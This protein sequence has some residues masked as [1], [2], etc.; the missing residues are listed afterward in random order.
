MDNPPKDSFTDSSFWTTEEKAQ[1]MLNMAYSQM[2]DAGMM[3]RDERLG[4]NV[5]EGR[6]NTST[7]MIRN[8]QA[9]ATTGL[10]ES[11][12]AGRYGCLKTCNLFLEKVDN[13]PMSDEKKNRMKAEIRYIRAATYLRLV[14]FYGDVP[15]F[16]KQIS[17]SEANTIART[18]RAE[19]M[20]FIHQELQ[21]I[22]DVLPSKDNLP[23]AERG[24]IT[25]GAVAMLDARAYLYDSDWANVVTRC[26]QL[27]DNQATWGQYSL[28]PE[29]IK[30][31][32]QDAEYNAEVIMDC[33]YVPSVRTW[34]DM[35]DMAPLSIGA[36]VNSTAPTR[37]LV[38]SY[39]TINGQSINDDNSWNRYQ[40]YAN[41]DPRLQATVV[42]NGYPWSDLV[43]DDT[44]D[45]IIWT[46]PSD[47]TDSNNQ[48][49]YSGNNA[50]QSPTGYYVRKYYD[51][52]HENNLA[53][54]TNIITMRYADVLLMY[55]EAKNELGQLD[56]TVWDK[57][58]KLVRQRAG[59]TASTGA[60]FP[61][62]SQDELR[63]TIRH[64]RRV[65][66]ALEGL[67]W[68]DIQRWKIG[69]TTLNGQVEG[70]DF[71]NGS[72]IKLD[73]RVFVKQRDYLWAVPQSQIDLNANLKPQNPGY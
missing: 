12:W 16:T 59:F 45:H 1:Y 63:E 67:R 8:G 44:K 21:E 20:A 26:E 24:R 46:N 54:A 71:D 60:N 41:R 69:D 65:E 17:L 39:Y 9:Q 32:T 34:G 49:K 52:K 70:D 50:N 14:T 19:V 30:L 10:F 62:S 55:A 27:I 35:L 56:A 51:E 68:F 61:G 47:A 13:V 42:Y 43:D 29:Y 5:M 31:F 23:A 25:K 64:E 37:S 66:L 57:T 18:P 22:A 15:F 28:Y 3:W 2:Y 7:R 36:R 40:P 72:A 53:S 4:D 33:S 73:K 11:E 48:D 6:L 38:D 58:M